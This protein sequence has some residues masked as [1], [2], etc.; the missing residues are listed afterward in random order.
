MY[1]RLTKQIGKFAGKRGAM[2]NKLGIAGAL[3]ALFYI[4]FS[5]NPAIS[6]EIPDQMTKQEVYNLA[7]VLTRNNYP[8]VDPVMLTAMAEIESAY[9]PNA[10]RY[11]SHINDASYG[12]MQT[13]YSTA[14]W[15]HDEMGY[16]AYTLTNPDQLFDPAVSMYFGGAYVDYLRKWNGKIRSEQWIVE[17]YNGGPN[18][19]NS[20]TRNHWNKYKIAKEGVL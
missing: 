12:L 1:K 8:N 4:A 3:T 2:F 11:E 9:K 13:L 20:Q 6:K 16:R 17:S 10:Y 18:N 7:F 14:K 15:L 19:S 5:R